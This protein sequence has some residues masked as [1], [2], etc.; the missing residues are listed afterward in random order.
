MARSISSI[1]GTLFLST[2]RVEKT[3][4]ELYDEIRA[5]PGV[6]TL[7]TKTL[8]KDKVAAVVKVDPYPYGGKFTQ[9]VHDKIIAEIIEIPGIRKFNVYESPFVKL[10]P[11]KVY[12]P[13]P[14]SFDNRQGNAQNTGQNVPGKSQST[15]TSPD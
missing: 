12:D 14:T 13:T 11:K 2:D 1:K 8:Q 10:E 9:E 4:T 7:N 15:G 3:Q 5:L 6:V